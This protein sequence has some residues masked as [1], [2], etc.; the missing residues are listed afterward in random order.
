[1]SDVIEGDDVRSEDEMRKVRQ[2]VSDVCYP[3][4]LQARQICGIGGDWRPVKK[5]PDWRKMSFEEWLPLS[6]LP[7]PYLA[8]EGVELA[9]AR[10]SFQGWASK[11]LFREHKGKCMAN[12]CSNS[13]SVQ[14]AW[15]CHGTCVEAYVCE[16]HAGRH[17]V[18]ADS[19]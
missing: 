12:S 17:G 13:A 6:T 19:I 10:P 7:A 2:W 4:R 3:P 1:M 14:I 16:E 9:L 18:W 5:Q 11:V 8:D 15:N